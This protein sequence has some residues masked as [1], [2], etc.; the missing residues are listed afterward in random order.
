MV[1]ILF[2]CDVCGH[3]FNSVLSSITSVGVLI[4]KSQNMS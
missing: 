1:K 4:V 2:D 3:E